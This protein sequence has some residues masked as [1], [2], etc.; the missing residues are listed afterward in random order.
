MTVMNNEDPA[1]PSAHHPGCPTPGRCSAHGCHGACLP[2]DDECESDEPQCPL[3][4]GDGM[5]PMTDYALPCPACE[6]E[7]L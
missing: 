5:D 1:D 3:C 4:H 7:R 6:G 2:E